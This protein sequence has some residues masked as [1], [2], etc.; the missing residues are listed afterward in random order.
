MS[1]IGENLKRYAKFKPEEIAMSFH[2][3]SISW[4]SLFKYVETIAQFLV[5]KTPKGA[6]IGIS[7]PNSIILVVIILAI[8]RTGRVA[9]VFDNN[10]PPTLQ[11]KIISEGNFDYLILSD[12]NESCDL[13]ISNPYHS[14]TC[15]SI[16]D[17]VLSKHLSPPDAELPFYIGFTSG[18]SG[19]LKGVKRSH[20]SWIKSFEMIQSELKNAESN[21]K[22]LTLG[23]LAHSINLYAVLEALHFGYE[24]TFFKQF[25]MKS[26]L[27]R[28]LHT[29]ITLIYGTPTQLSGLARF[30]AERKGGSFTS[31]KTIMTGGSKWS[32]EKETDLKKLFPKAEVFEFYGAS[33]TSYISMSIPSESPPDRSVGRVCQGVDLKILSRAKIECQA[34]ELGKIWVKSKFNFESYYFGANSLYER[35]GEW[36]TIGDVGYFDQNGFLFL[37]GRDD[38]MFNVSGHNIFPEEIEQ[39]LTKSCFVSEVAVVG[40]GHYLRE[41]IIVAVLLA[42]KK[43]KVSVDKLRL[44]CKKNLLPYKVPHKF[45]LIKDWPMLTSGK[46]DYGSIQLVAESIQKTNE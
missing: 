7:L 2:K 3:D 37:C 41:K 28:I 22:Y 43:E 12:D 6:I 25:N 16:F 46:T 35:V 36:I 17:T 26:V 18:S 1:W 11:K 15:F 31:V 39:V 44:L 32:R 33:E 38:R 5:K 4:A 24:I 45:I 9:T 13:F 8:A 14:R 40:V 21:Q 30:A 19:G 20:R 34:G 42:S 23:G 10:W 27:D 29:K